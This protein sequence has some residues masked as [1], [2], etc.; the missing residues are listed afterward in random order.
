[1]V[2]TGLSSVHKTLSRRSHE[3]AGSC[4][5]V[6]HVPTYIPIELAG[7]RKK[8]EN[9]R[10]AVHGIDLLKLLSFLRLTVLIAQG[11]SNLYLISPFIEES[12]YM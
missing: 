2:Q 11:V 12:N 5:K 3:L 6:L 9:Y 7:K 8:R 1:M 10:S 4:L